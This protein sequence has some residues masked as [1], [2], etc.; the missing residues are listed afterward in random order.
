M[1]KIRIQIIS[2]IA[3]EASYSILVRL[4]CTC[5]DL[6]PNTF[7]FQVTFILGMKAY[8][9]L[10]R[11]KIVLAVIGA[12]QLAAYIVFLIGLPTTGVSR[13]LSG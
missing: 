1:S 4:S 10:K 13:D 7:C 5:F 3:M 8:R 2:Y 9:C 12:L 11:S 6:C